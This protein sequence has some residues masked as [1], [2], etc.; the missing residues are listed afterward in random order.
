MD[1]DE[2]PL[3]LL[4]DDGDGVIETCLFFDEKQNKNQGGQQPPGNSGC[5]IVLAVIGTSLLVARWGVSLI[6]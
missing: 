3:D 2:D 4:D 1:L 5:C 6:I